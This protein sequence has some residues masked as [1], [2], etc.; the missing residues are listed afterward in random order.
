MQTSQALSQD[1]SAL[2]VLY[3][4]RLV[5]LQDGGSSPA[6]ETSFHATETDLWVNGLWFVSLTLSLAVALFAVLAKQWLRQYM[7]IVMGTPRERAFIRQF[8]Y[9]GLK[10]WRVPTIVGVIPVLLYISVVLFLIGLSVFLAPLSQTM[11]YIVATITIIIVVLYLVSTILPLLKP[12]CP[13]RTTFTDLVHYL[14]AT[15]TQT[16]WT[17]LY[18]LKNRFPNVAPLLSSEKAEHRQQK[19]T[20]FDFVER[21]A[22]SPPDRKEGDQHAELHALRW[23]A[24]TTS[25]PSAKDIAFESIG[26]FHSKMADDVAKLGGIFGDRE[27]RYLGGD[28]AEDERG[29]RALVHLRWSDEALR[30]TYSSDRRGALTQLAAGYT[31]EFEGGRLIKPYEGVEWAFGEGGF[32][33]SEDVSEVVWAG[34]FKRAEGLVLKDAPVNLLQAISVGWAGGHATPLCLGEWVTRGHVHGEMS[35]RECTK[36]WREDAE[37]A[38]AGWDIEAAGERGVEE[39]LGRWM[40]ECQ[41]SI[42]STNLWGKMYPTWWAEGQA[43]LDERVN[44]D[45]GCLAEW[46][47]EAETAFDALLLA[48]NAR[49]AEGVCWTEH[50]KALDTKSYIEKWKQERAQT[51]GK[52]LSRFWR[53]KTAE[54]AEDVT[55]A[56]PVSVQSWA[57]RYSRA[58]LIWVRNWCRK[59]DE[60]P[61]SHEMESIVTDRV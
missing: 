10:N 11:S 19:P 59:V 34:L 55:T 28:S 50:L 29:M 31:V 3:L 47:E 22:A 43:R 18:S 33:G 39:L 9:D 51:F 60:T 53:W 38:L 1:N 48:A 21:K 41:R 40:E 8:R 25:S 17:V 27:Y 52:E 7:S 2:S 12:K 24:E 37:E 5:A 4:A 45:D 46:E 35:R 6:V 42:K 14:H 23:L 54:A 15:T 16:I 44:A 57:E 20:S 13:Y 56:V 61:D 32:T 30:Y 58:A 36:R 49:K 26:A